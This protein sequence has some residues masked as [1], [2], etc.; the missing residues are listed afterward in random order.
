L[1]AP[2][3]YRARIRLRLDRLIHVPF[4]F[5]FSGSQIIFAEPEADYSTEELTP[6]TSPQCTVFEHY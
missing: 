5:E 6:R 2:P 1:F 3:E 4:Q